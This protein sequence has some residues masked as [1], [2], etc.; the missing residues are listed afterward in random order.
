MVNHPSV[1]ESRVKWILFFCL[2]KVLT[3]LYSYT[4]PVRGCMWLFAES[5]IEEQLP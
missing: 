1:L 3:I 4:S 5:K 2:G